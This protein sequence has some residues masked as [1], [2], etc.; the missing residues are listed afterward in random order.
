MTHGS[1]LATHPRYWR[2]EGSVPQSASRLRIRA[3]AD[4]IPITGSSTMNGDRPAQQ[5]PVTR[6]TAIAI[7]TNTISKLIAEFLARL[8]L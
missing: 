1:S 8:L 3:L 2:S 7:A 6:D 4:P 5:R